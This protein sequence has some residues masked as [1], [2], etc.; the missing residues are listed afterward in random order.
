MWLHINQW[1]LLFQITSL[2]SLWL[3]FTDA[4]SWKLKSTSLRKYD[5][6]ETG[7]FMIRTQ[8]L[9]PFY[10]TSAT[11]VKLWGRHAEDCLLVILI[12]TGMFVDIHLK[13]KGWCGP[14]VDYEQIELFVNPP[15]QSLKF[16]SNR[17]KSTS[18]LR[19]IL[20]HFCPWDNS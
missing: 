14:L 12:D 13:Y 1:K 18:D 15:K 9:V 20:A 6:K 3:L 5:F 10:A 16:A 11:C 17:G 8:Q 19:T 7:I 2:I 4:L